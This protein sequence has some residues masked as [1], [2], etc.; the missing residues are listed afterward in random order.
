[1][2][3]PAIITVVYPRPS[4]PDAAFEF[5]YDHY[6]K[7]HMP[8]IQETW[9]PKGLKSW[10]VTEHADK[11]EP[12]FLQCKMEW[13]SVEDFQKA[14]TAEDSAKVFADVPNFTNIDLKILKG[15]VVRK[16]TIL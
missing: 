7:V 11:D 14:S 15:E 8:L 4:K 10:M 5:D 1:M 2:P 9:G 6:Y 16:W 3:G 13:D 12:Y